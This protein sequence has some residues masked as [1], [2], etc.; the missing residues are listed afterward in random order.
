MAKTTNNNKNTSFLWRAIFFALSFIYLELLFHF[1]IYKNFSRDIIHPVLFA[2][3]TGL[4]LAVITSL[5]K[6]V[7]NA[8]AAYIIF[9]VFS[10][11]YV[12]QLIYYRIFRTFLSLVSIGGAGDA[13]NFKTV[14]FSAIFKN[15]IWIILLLLPLI[16]LI[17]INRF[18]VSF[19][20]P[21]LK[22]GLIG[23][24]SAVASVVLAIGILPFFGRDTYSPY[25]LFHGRY[26]LELSMNR[27]GVVVTTIRDGITMISGDK[28]S[29]SFDLNESS[30]E[31]SLTDDSED[32]EEESTLSAENEDDPATSA[33]SYV[34]QID[35]SLDFYKLYNNTEDE[36]LKNLSAYF[37]NVAPTYTNEYTGLFK[38]YNVIFVTAESL[39]KY[40]ISKECTPTLY[41][42][43]NEG[44]VFDN[45]YD[46][47]WYHSTI[48]G[49]Y[50][51]CLSQYPCS[52]D[53]SFEKS[54]KTYQPYAL[55]NALNKLGYNS[56]A[57]HD[58]D[59]TYYDR[60]TTHPNMGYTT[61]KAIDYGLDIPFYNM[62]SDLDAME[63]VYNDFITDD[64][65]NMYF[66]SFSGHLPYD[67][68]YQYMCQK[69]RE[70][71]ESLV[72]R[73]DL[74]DEAIAYIAAQME[75]DKALEF[76]I[77][78]LDKRGKLEKTVFIVGPDHYP[79]GLTD[80]VYNELA[81]KNI[82]DDPFE[83]H[84]NGFGIWSASMEKPVKVDKLCS[85]VD[86]L[87]TV[88]NLLGVNYDSRLLAGHDLMSD[89][90]ELVIF[91]NQS[92]ITDKVRYNA[93]TGETIYTVPESTVP[94]GY[95]ESIIEEVENRLY[96]S[97][98]L[99]DEDYFN[100]IY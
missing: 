58:F 31:S 50:T 17:V 1:A 59:A 75:L 80:G 54:G 65:F 88:L 22:Q 47:L 12:A 4:V 71:A 56:Y 16:C 49:E 95:L 78:E 98:L 100:Y 92:F 87:P 29:K 60:T 85:S 41:K 94:E 51:N 84:S 79:Y 33:P 52:S 83:L 28:S 23:V 34:P 81:G 20:R 45:Y 35:E 5:F 89:F 48:D 62:Y 64:K 40:G 21:A 39:S 27:L 14:M 2:I 43:Y 42:I 44:F 74:S 15:I 19:K 38:D 53:W 30:S 36:D 32:I 46:P 67:Y 86:I 99:I 57:Y 66:M 76:L 13:M 55:G 26:I 25:T 91:A 97:N 93:A 96:I 82:E 72:A 11:Y 37:S 24:A 6:K 69:N 9:S 18:F 3:C 61:F 63:A 73:D 90:E 70:E 10:V 8:I 68:S 77:N 7:G